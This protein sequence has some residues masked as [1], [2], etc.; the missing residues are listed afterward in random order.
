MMHI[1]GEH[2]LIYNKKVWHKSDD[3]DIIN[4]T[5]EYVTLVK[6]LDSLENVN[7][8]ISIVGYFIFDSNYDK[9]IFLTQ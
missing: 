1:K 7:H 6:L 3:F 4:N 5:S 9:A 8:A 2:H